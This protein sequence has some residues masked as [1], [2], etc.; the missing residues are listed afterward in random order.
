MQAVLFDLYGTLL[1]FEDD[2]RPFYELA[3]RTTNQQSAIQQSAIQH[4]LTSN[5]ATL[6]EFADR[7]GLPPQP[8]ITTLQ[9]S[10]EADI[11]RIQPFSE[12]IEVLT[13]LKQHHIKIA[14]VSNL[15]TPYK[16]PYY[17]HG[18][19]ALVDVPVFSYD[20]GYA[21]PQ[22]EIYRLALQHLNSDPADTLMVGDSFRSD[23]EGPLQLGIQA[24]HL[25]RNDKT[26][27]AN[28][29]IT[30]LLEVISM[31]NIT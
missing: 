25:V 8:D 30:S 17:T 22:P 20:C 10:L 18:F 12:V 14:V 27:P 5:N 29:T 26:S 31:Y 23:V 24:A 11:Q 28:N 19:D 16:Q 7:I 2:S 21:K 3:C 6:S 15:A 1:E 13:T 4:A 9:T